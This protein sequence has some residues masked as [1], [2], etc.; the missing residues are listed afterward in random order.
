VAVTPSQID[1]LRLWFAALTGAGNI[2]HAHSTDELTRAY[3]RDQR[4]LV[5]RKVERLLE[6]AWHAAAERDRGR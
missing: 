2:L 4:D 3:W 1:E 6:D 5:Q